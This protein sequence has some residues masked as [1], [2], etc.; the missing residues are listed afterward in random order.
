MKNNKSPSRGD[1]RPLKAVRHQLVQVAVVGMLA[2]MGVSMT[3]VRPAMAMEPSGEIRQYNIP[4]GSLHDVLTTYSVTNNIALSFDPALVAGK[5][6]PGL[7]GSYTPREGLEQILSNS[8]LGL[9]PQ[10]NDGYT[11]YR[12]PPNVPTHGASS[13]PAAG[14]TLQELEVQALRPDEDQKR[15]VYRQSVSTIYMDDTNFTKFK[16]SNVADIFRGQVGVYSGDARNGDVLDP[17]I[18]GIQGQGRV[19]LTIDGTEQAITKSKGFY[20]GAN[21]ANYI[22]PNLIAGG[23]VVKGAAIDRNVQTSSG[24]GIALRTIGA[25]DILKPGQ[26]FGI[27][28]RIDGETNTTSPRFPDTMPEGQ[29]YHVNNGAEATQ[30]TQE[31][32]NRY[33][34]NVTPRDN[35]TLLNSK[36]GSAM[37][38]VAWQNEDFNLL[39]AYSYRKRG[40]YFAGR[41]GAEKYQNAGMYSDSLPQQYDVT[42]SVAE[43]YKAGKEVT[44][45]SSEAES[46]LAKGEWNITDNMLLGFGVRTTE[47]HTGAIS[48]TAIRNVTEAQLATGQV[49]QWPEGE[50]KQKAYNLDYAWKPEDNRFVD[51]QAK[52]WKTETNSDDFSGRGALNGLVEIV[53]DREYITAQSNRLDVQNDR[54]GFSV[55]NKFQLHDTL[56]LLVGGNYQYETLDVNARWAGN[57][58]GGQ[59]HEN[60]IYFNFNWQ[61]LSWLE[62]DAGAK[63][64]A[65]SMKDKGYLEYLQNNAV[66]ADNRE[67]P[68]VARQFLVGIRQ[69]RYVPLLISGALTRAGILG[70]SDTYINSADLE[71]TLNTIYRSGRSLAGFLQVDSDGKLSSNGLAELQKMLD[72]TFGGLVSVSDLDLSTMAIQATSGLY[73]SDA[74]RAAPN[75][76]VK[77]TDWAPSFGVTFKGFHSRLYFRYAQDIRMPSMAEGTHGGYVALLNSRE[78]YGLDPLQPE[79]ARNIEVGLSHDFSRF[80]KQGTVAD[81]KIAYFDQ[82]IKNVID[83]V[84]LTRGFV[85]ANLDQ[86]KIRGVE[87]QSRFDSGRFFAEFSAIRNLRNEV[88][89]KNEAIVYSS[90]PGEISECVN[91][92]FPH[93]ILLNTKQP[94]H[95]LNLMLG[96]RLFDNRLEFG[97]RVTY[98]TTYDRETQY[99]KLTSNLVGMPVNWASTTV[100]DAYA[101]YQITKN[102][103]IEFSAMNLTDRYYVDPLAR[104]WMPAPGRTLRL[105]LRIDI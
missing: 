41:H 72:T 77:D 74:N 62:L 69:D 87:F 44:N 94:K 53:P 99:T 21:N 93:G 57:V 17:N 37:A 1:D 73:L 86:Q 30:L 47:M 100:V 89:D 19:P 2:G 42:A 56:N 98:F 91:Y 25:Q 101:N 70:S 35:P 54:T 8:G 81:A 97:T 71:T 6:S 23:T 24:G 5:Q 28:L 4:A 79:K 75:G 15:A 67:K 66:A 55:S 61:P 18:R 64:R 58:R 16:G 63:R 43:F 14:V 27:R 48:P 29:V 7:Q 11:L 65:F 105:G 60:D 31:F 102:T 104:S 50:S 82:N 88:C 40:N 76:K 20:V 26:R 32:S 12:L 103:L 34:T 38:A 68:L 49:F 52:L 90:Y 45:T 36:S 85:S 46:F 3:L 92:G 10:G 22:D 80:F 84:V 33:P 83:T 39:A 78:M 9:M 13:R 95:S 51:L 59:R 96:S